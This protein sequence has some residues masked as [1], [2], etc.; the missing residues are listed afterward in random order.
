MSGNKE[1]YIIAINDEKWYYINDIYKIMV[2]HIDIN[3]CVNHNE[4]KSLSSIVKNTTYDY[5]TIIKESKIDGLNRH[6]K[7][8]N[9]SG[10]NKIANEIISD[11]KREIELLDEEMRM[12]GMLDN[13]DEIKYEKDDKIIVATCNTNNKI[14]TTNNDKRKQTGKIIVATNN[15]DMVFNDN[16]SNP[17][18]QLLKMFKY[19]GKDVMIL[20][21]N[22]EVWFRAKEIAEILDYTNLKKSIRDHVD[23]DDKIILSEL[24]EKYPIHRGNESFP[25]NQYLKTSIFINEVGMYSLILRSKQA[26]AKIFKKWITSEIL[27]SLRKHGSYSIQPQQPLLKNIYNENMLLNYDKKNCVYIAYIGIHSNE[28][29]YKFGMTSDIYRRQFKEHE[30]TFDQFELIYVKETDN[31]EIVEEKFKKELQCKHLLRHLKIKNKSQ[32][33]LFTITN[34]HNLDMIKEYMDNII[35]SCVLPCIKEKDTQLVILE[36]DMRLTLFEKLDENKIE[37]KR[38]YNDHIKSLECQIKSLEKINSLESIIS[39]EKIKSLEN[40]LSLLKSLLPKKV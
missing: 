10:Y 34:I 26:N 7:F 40:E 5:K 33:E 30:N 38:M 22:D 14:I 37:M 9:K 20:T 28:P 12:N 23:D 1:I 36:K 31:K 3:K 27:P 17:F 2:N 6:S 15:N 29:L 21:I 13:E 16:Q 19:S 4:M 18:D 11:S 35:N 25:L 39:Q 8:V 32:V 24:L